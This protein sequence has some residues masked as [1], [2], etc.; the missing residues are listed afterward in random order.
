[1]KKKLLPK[2]LD[3]IYLPL[4]KLGVRPNIRKH[5]IELELLDLAIN[6]RA[7]GQSQPILVYKKS[8]KSGE[9][10][11]LDGQRRL[12]AFDL[13]NTEYPDEGWD[14]IACV[15]RDEPE[16][17]DKKMAISLG[18]NMTQL[19]MTVDDIQVAV[20]RLWNRLSNMKLVAETYGISEKTAKK[21]VKGARLNQRLLDASTSV[22]VDEDPEKALDCIMEAV[23]LFNWTKENDVSDDKVINAAK[24]FA[25]KTQGDKGEIITEW[26]KDPEQELEDVLDTVKNN[27]DEKKPKAVRIVLPPESDTSL[28]SYAKSRKKK[29]A[30]AASEIVI[31]QLKK[32]VSTTDED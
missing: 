10:E 6:I 19:Q 31:D 29:R 5:N 1:L 7:N 32:L 11:V 27:P 13:L 9:W 15:E 26:E 4:E 14:E 18:G 25:Q 16:D 24:T 20:L 23:D 30:E 3:L 22:E 12:N 21:Y 2:K 28:T 17:E 8:D